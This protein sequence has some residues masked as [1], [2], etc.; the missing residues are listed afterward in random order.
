M[1]PQAGYELKPL[2][3]ELTVY[4]VLPVD[5]GLESNMENLF[6]P[7]SVTC[8]SDVPYSIPGICPDEQ[9]FAAYD[10]G[11]SDSSRFYGVCEFLSDAAKKDTTCNP[12]YLKWGAEFSELCPRQED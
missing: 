6:G 7:F 8:P 5:N 9:T 12:I 10:L 4:L 1:C 2:G 3:R 11:L